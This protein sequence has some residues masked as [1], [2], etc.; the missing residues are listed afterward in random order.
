MAATWSRV[1]AV[2]DV[3]LAAWA[4]LA[5]A[6]AARWR[7]AGPVDA[8][9]VGVNLVA[10]SP[11][12]LARVRARRRDPVALLA[13]VAVGCAVVTTGRSRPR[14]APVAAVSVLVGLA[15][16]ERAR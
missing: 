16:A 1:D 15:V 6:R 5:V 10:G 7:A 13:P 4:L 3:S 9:V 12:A 14:W 2:H 8:A 11:A